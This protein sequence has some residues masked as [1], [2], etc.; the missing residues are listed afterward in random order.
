MSVYYK[1]VGT[2]TWLTDTAHSAISYVSAQP[3]IQPPGFRERTRPLGM[4][5]FQGEKLERA[6]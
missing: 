5:R 4:R 6:T 1:T 3:S 2:S